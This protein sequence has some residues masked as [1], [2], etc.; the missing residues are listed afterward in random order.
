[1]IS[2]GD[3]HVLHDKGL[4]GP[5]LCTLWVYDHVAWLNTLAVKPDWLG[6]VYQGQQYQINAA[7]H[8]ICDLARSNA[9]HPQTDGQTE[10]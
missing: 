1:M 6:A 7:M 5:V 8:K 10:Q 2:S 9:G 4:T 3:I